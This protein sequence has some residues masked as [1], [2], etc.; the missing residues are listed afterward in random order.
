MLNLWRAKTTYLSKWINAKECLP[1]GQDS[2]WIIKKLL[3]RLESTI[4]RPTLPHDME[5]KQLAEII[6]QK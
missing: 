3:N 1:P 2:N 5:I 6:L 4:G